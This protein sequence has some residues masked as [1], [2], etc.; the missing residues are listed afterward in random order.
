[1]YA[2]EYHR[3]A[4]VSEAANLLGKR[5]DAKALAGGQTMIATMKQRLAQPSDLV[6][7]TG[8]A[9]MR[10]IKLEGSSLSI[11]ATTRHAEVAASADVKGSIRALAVLASTI[12]DRQVRGMGSIGGSVANNDPAAD[13]PAGVLGLDATIVTNKRRIASG[14]FFTGMYET[15]LQPGELITSISFPVPK[16]A[17][18]AKFANPASRFA[19]IGVFVAQTASGAVCVAV[20]GGGQGVFRVESMEKALAA[21]FSVEALAGIKV[22]P[23]R[24]NGDLHASAEYRAQLIGVMARRAVTAALG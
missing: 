17:G 5:S 13:Y 6:D 4:T 14:D 11:G 16:R 23:D 9:E 24:L 7:L 22:S 3:P 10:G 12:G 18:Y 8:I 1:M 19:L 15:A 20:T 2:F 21:N